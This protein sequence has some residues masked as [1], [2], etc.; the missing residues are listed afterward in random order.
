MVVAGDPSPIINVCLSAASPTQTHTR[1][2]T[3]SDS[4]MNAS[5]RCLCCHDSSQARTGLHVCADEASARAWVV[6]VRLANW[7]SCL[8]CA[9]VPV[10]EEQPPDSLQPAAP[11]PHT[12]H[13]RSRLEKSRYHAD[14]PALQ[15]SLSRQ[16]RG[17]PNGL[18]DV[19]QDW[20]NCQTS[21]WMT[22]VLPHPRKLTLCVFILSPFFAVCFETLVH[23]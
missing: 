4:V 12:H 5:T 11:A 22:K 14:I 17:I 20:G 1:S 9:S 19:G 10:V 23:V 13:H 3:R 15:D 6:A 8:R 21:P 2:K 18:T 7:R 16:E